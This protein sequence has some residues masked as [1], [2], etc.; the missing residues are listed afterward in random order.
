LS[1]LSIEGLRLKLNMEVSVL[2]HSPE[3]AR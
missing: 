2:S 3:S 1:G